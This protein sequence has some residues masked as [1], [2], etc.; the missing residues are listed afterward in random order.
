MG[1]TGLVHVQQGLRQDEVGGTDG[2][3]QGAAEG[4]GVHH[5]AAVV[6]ALHGGDGPGGI[7]EF[8]VV[9]VLD[10]IAMGGGVGPAEQLGPP[11]GGHGRA[12]GELVGG[13]HVGHS[14]P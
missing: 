6:H 12:G 10:E 13:G 2:G 8:A 14:G 11:S 5:P 3:G 9:V 4:A 7:A 1:K